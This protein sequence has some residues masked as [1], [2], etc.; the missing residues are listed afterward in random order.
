[1]YLGKL[2]ARPAC[3]ADYFDAAGEP[4]L[5]VGLGLAYPNPNPNPDP[6]PDPNPNPNQA[7]AEETARLEAALKQARIDR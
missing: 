5:G 3:F 4:C 6:N 1:M 7:A 2:W